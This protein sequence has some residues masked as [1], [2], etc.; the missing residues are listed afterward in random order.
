MFINSILND[1]YF[2]EFIAG[3][4]PNKM[5]KI[6]ETIDVGKA[7]YK[8]ITR[9]KLRTDNIAMDKQKEANIY[10]NIYLKNRRYLK[11]FCACF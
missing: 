2:R 1:D 11:E 5:E 7:I 9:R 3:W 10:I 6:K 4:W 8:Y